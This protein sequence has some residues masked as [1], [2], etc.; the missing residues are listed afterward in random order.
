MTGDTIPV[1]HEQP[2]IDAALS[3]DVFPVDHRPGGDQDA[4]NGF[5]NA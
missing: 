4:G 3:T 5:Y 2:V 1:I